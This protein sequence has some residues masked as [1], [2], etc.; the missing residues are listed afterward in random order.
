MA[1]VAPLLFCTDASHG[2][3]L[4]MLCMHI[5]AAIFFHLHSFACAERTLAPRCFFLRLLQL[6]S[7]HV[8]PLRVLRVLRA[9]LL[10]FFFLTFSHGVLLLLSYH[11]C[12]ATSLPRLF[13]PWREWCRSTS[14]G[15]FCC[16]FTVRAPDGL[17]LCAR[18]VIETDSFR[19]AHCSA[20]KGL[21]GAVGRGAPSIH[22]LLLPNNRARHLYEACC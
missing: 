5:Q 8:C 14:S 7:Y 10:L 12:P 13:V 6:L 22:P 3:V 2:R 4:C 15:G 19:R 16:A 18:L 17:L 20:S 9:S 11:P 1:V 21:H